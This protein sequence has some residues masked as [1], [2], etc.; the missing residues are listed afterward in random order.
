[1]LSDVI[2]QSGLDF[3]LG[4]SVFVILCSIHSV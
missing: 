1:M 4:T 3:T 2:S